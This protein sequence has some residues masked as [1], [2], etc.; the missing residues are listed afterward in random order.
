[1]AGTGGVV[2]PGVGD[3]ELVLLDFTLTTAALPRTMV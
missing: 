3:G 2:L 1:M